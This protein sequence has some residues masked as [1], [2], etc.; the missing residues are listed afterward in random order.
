MADGFVVGVSIA[1]D[2]DGDVVAV[3]FANGERLSAAEA[4]LILIDAARAMIALAAE[5]DQETEH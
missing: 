2:D 4:G 1:I 3:S 5:A